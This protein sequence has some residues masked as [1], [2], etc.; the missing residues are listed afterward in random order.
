MRWAY[1]FPR[2]AHVLQPVWSACGNATKPTT[3]TKEPKR[4]EPVEDAEPTVVLRPVY[5]PA[6]TFAQML[7]LQIFFTIWGGGFFGGFSLVALQFIDLPI[8]KWLPFVGFGLA[9]FVG[10]PALVMGTARRSTEQTEYRFFRHKLEYYE[11][12]FNV[13]QKS[14]AL[15]DVTEVSLTKG[16]LQSKYGLGTVVLANRASLGTGRRPGIRLANI[17]NPDEV[18]RNVKQLVERARFG[19]DD[20]RRAA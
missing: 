11:G 16:V 15:A 7:P 13:E 2:N 4:S 6:L 9:F 12:F 18:Y 1:R 3:A 10:I 5:V 17:E 20:M 14:I 8:P 19:S